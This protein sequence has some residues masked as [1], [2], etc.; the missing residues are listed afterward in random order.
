MICKYLNNNNCQ[1]ASDIAQIECPVL[2]SQCEYCTN[3]AEPKQSINPV[4]VSIA[5]K[6]TSDIPRVINQYGSVITQKVPHHNQQPG[7][8]LRNLISWFV[9]SAKVRNCT[10]CKNREERM[11]K[12]GAD[13]CEKNMATIVGWL[14]E[15]AVEKGYPFSERVAVALIKKAIANSRKRK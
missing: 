15:S 6:Y 13:K 3:K 10:T 2:E 8:E 4:T 9:W 14:K 1:I 5:L 12:W 11:N 7:T